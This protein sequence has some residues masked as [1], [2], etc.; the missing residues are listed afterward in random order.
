MKLTQKILITAALA[1]VLLITLWAGLKPKGYRF[2]NNATWLQRTCGIAIGPIGIAY[3]RDSLQWLRQNSQDTAF[4]IELSVEGAGLTANGC[5]YVLSFWDGTLPEPMM[6]GQWL[7]HLIVRVRDLNAQKG[8]RE[9][10]A[11]HVFDR[12]KKQLIQIVSSRSQTVFYINGD[13]T[14]EPLSA[15]ILSKNGLR[16]RLILGNSALANSPWQGK[17]HGISMCKKELSPEEAAL[18]FRQ[19]DSLGRADLPPMAQAA[20][21]FRFDETQGAIAHD[22]VAN[23]F[24]LQ[25]PR[26]FHIIKKR[27]LTG[28]W[29]DFQW[30]RSYLLDIL[31]N[32]AGFIPLGFLM[33]LFLSEIAGI[34]SRKKNL[35]LTVLVCFIISLC[36]ELAQV[37]IPTRS[38]QLSDLVLNTLGGLLGGIFVKMK[39]TSA[40]DPLG[41]LFKKQ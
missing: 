4:T 28:P 3:S 39:H 14:G 19:W 36:I 22:C 15:S 27:V 30:D 18:R 1:L 38:S 34:Q 31:V 17:F 5:P 11:L 23:G 41:G 29:D 37:Y 16:G 35:V 24:D 8:Y 9:F 40:R 20:H 10:G 13:R 21:F 6:I 32:L 7:N 12:G 2:R 33:A 25:I 26:L